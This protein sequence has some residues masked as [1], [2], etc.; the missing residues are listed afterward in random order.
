MKNFYVTTPIYYVNDAPHIGHSYTTVLA[1]I[2]TRFHKLLGYQTFFLTGTDEHGQKVQRAA[3]KRGV[4]PQE[5]V[6]E[7]NLRFKNRWKKMDIG[8]DFF[9]RTTDADHKQFVSQCL[10]MLWDKGQIYSKEYEGWY[11]VGEERFFTQDE[12][13]ENGC[14]PIS[15][16]PVDWIKEKNYFFKMGSYQQQ[17]ID[18]LESH[19]DWIVPD[20]RWNEIRGFLKQPL[21]DLCISRPK[22][23]LSWGIPLPFD[24]DYVTYVWF[25]AL[26]NYV[27]AVMKLDENGNLV[28]RRTFANGEPIWPASYHLVGKD[29]ITTHSVYWPTMLFALGFPLPKHILAHG[30]WLVGND[31]MSKTTG[32]VVNP[33]DYMEKYGVDS[34]R[35]YLA[36][37][38]VVGQD[39]SFTHEGF[40]RRINGDLANDLGNVV[41]RVHRLVLTHFGGVL[42]KPEFPFGDEEKAIQNQ[43]EKLSASVNALLENVK[44]SQA[45]EEIMSL[46]RSVNRYFE[47]KAPWKMAKEESRKGELATVLFTA[48]EAIRLALSFLSPIIPSKSREGLAMLGTSLDSVQD[49]NWGKFQGGEKFGEGAAL[50][51]RIVEEIKK[52]EAQAKPKQNK[53]LSAEDVPAAMDIRVAKIVDVQNHPDADSLYVLKVDAGE[54]EMRTI[55]SGLRASYTAEELQGRMIVLFANLKPAPLRGIMSNGMLFAGDTNTEHV[56]KLLTPPESAKPGDR[57]LFQG[58]APS[59]EARVLKVK[60]FEKISLDVHG[61]VVFCGKN[62][63]EVNGQPVKCDV[64][65]GAKVH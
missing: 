45:V 39:A 37:D 60:D 61:Q 38:M 58:I 41:N 20:Y 53:P 1:D 8:Y 62:A 4:S 46:V 48:A 27:S 55:C 34:F 59:A 28:P 35:Y 17:L 56:C 6:D 63:L 21:N 36:R 47:L 43:S 50:F 9:I 29:I 64:A 16:R 49:L 40:I 10:Q 31:K 25:D 22:A 19:K 44:L 13:D 3:A 33:M 52:P 51:P 12:L 26:L 7:Y 15:H 2:L 54:P 18:Y 30:W 14:D 11:S 42:P 24:T 32:N 57:A 5:H 65:E 23:R